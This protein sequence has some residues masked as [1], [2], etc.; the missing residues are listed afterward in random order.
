[1]SLWPVPP[2]FNL[3]SYSFPRYFGIRRRCVF[4]EEFLCKLELPSAYILNIVFYSILHA[5]PQ[6]AGPTQFIPHYSMGLHS[7]ITH[8]LFMFNSLFTSL[9][10]HRLSFVEYGCGKHVREPV[11]ETESSFT[12]FKLWCHFVLLLCWTLKEQTQGP[13]AEPNLSSH[14]KHEVCEVC[15][16][17]LKNASSLTAAGTLRF[18]SPV[19]K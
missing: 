8:V 18:I 14:L 5:H 12:L 16:R 4:E 1:M 19:W 11:S 13:I 6:L 17:T 9:R 7:N 15:K 10:L 2:S 3:R